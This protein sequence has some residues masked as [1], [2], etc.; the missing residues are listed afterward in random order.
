MKRR[1]FLDE[2]TVRRPLEKTFE[3]FSSAE[4]LQ[5][6]TP[7]ELCFKILTPSPIKIVE[8][9]LLDYRL[10][11]HGVPFS[12]QTRIAL[13]NPPHEF[14]DQQSKGPYAFWS[15]HHRFEAVEPNLTSVKDQVV[16]QLPFE[17]LGGLG[18]FFIKKQI[19]KIFA[20]RRK[21]ITQFL[22]A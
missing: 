16:Y 19:Q 14:I 3:F 2:F 5:L 1:T 21:A 15:H 18:H 4:N 7:P 8:G 13:W 20:Y 22:E 6:I 10:K 11:L 17:P 12:W 9:A